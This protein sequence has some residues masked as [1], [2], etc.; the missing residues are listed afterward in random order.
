MF[1]YILKRLAMGVVVVFVIATITFWL[2]R[3]LPG[4]P[5]DRDKPLNPTIIENLNKKYNLDRPVTE[6]YIDYMVDVAQFDF[7]PSYYYENETVNDYINRCFPVS[8]V[9]GVGAMIV[10]IVLG[11][12]AGVISAL[13]Q[14]GWQD[15]IIKILTT[16]LVSLPN[17]V[18]ASALMY[19]IG[20]KLRL[21]PVALWGTPQQ[22]I[23]PTLALAAYPLSY[24]TKM[25]KSS[26]LEVMN[27]DYIR[28]AK[29]KGASQFLIVYKHAL[30]NAVLPV[31]TVVGP[32]FAGIITGS[33]VVEKLFA[34][35]GL[36]Q[37]FTTSIFN[38]DYPM[39]MGLT[40]FYSILLIAATLIVDVVYAMVDPRIKLGKESK[41]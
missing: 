4:G 7:G 31:I 26:M 40:I 24:I 18:I 17:F 1:K 34:I 6:Q 33:L 12:P 15:N 3:A 28:T 35:P 20:Y 41:E 30:K 37:Q 23:M 11:I 27:S 38:R 39:I 21:L 36:G 9:L 2:S 8:L 29:A 16:I 19:F 10:A 5:F 14:N 32:M 25:M 22:A 13:K